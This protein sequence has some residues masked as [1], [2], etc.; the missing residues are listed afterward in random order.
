MKKVLLLTGD[1]YHNPPGGIDLD[2]PKKWIRIV[3]D[4][5]KAGAVQGIDIDFAEPLD[6]ITFNGHPVP[7]GKQQENW[8]IDNCSCKNLGIGKI[9]GSSD[10][11]TILNW[12]YKNYG[13]HGFWNN[14]KPYLD[15]DEF[16]AI[17]V[18]SVSILKVSEVSIYHN[19]FGKS[20]IDFKWSGH[21]ICGISM[22]G[23]DYFEELNNGH[24]ITFDNA[25]IV[26]SIPKEA[27]F[28]SMNG[29]RRA[30]K[31]VSRVYEIPTL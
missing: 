27:D 17:E 25:Y 29:E 9:N 8:A 3:A 1:Y 16:E 11:I 18:P 23:R 2:N 21:K 28:V 7:Q 10:T 15:E 19:Y 26:I 14:S 20:K 13:Y 12:A 5:G 22:A 4:D 30:Y 31:F 24:T 6:V